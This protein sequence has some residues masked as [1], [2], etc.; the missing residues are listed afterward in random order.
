MEEH[1]GMLD[2]DACGAGHSGAGRSWQV[3][4]GELSPTIL[5]YVAR[6]DLP[7]RPSAH[8][9]PPGRAHATAARA[10]SSLPTLSTFP[11]VYSQTS[12]TD[13][14]T[15]WPLPPENYLNLRTLAGNKRRPDVQT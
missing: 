1:G 7:G 11:E 12:P 4:S 10:S 14:Q 3:S 9:W 6:V 5:F 13:S 2:D 15:F 8:G